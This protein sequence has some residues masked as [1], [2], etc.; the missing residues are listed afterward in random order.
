MSKRLDRLWNREMNEFGVEVGVPLP[1]K[2]SAGENEA[3]GKLFC[4]KVA[5][6]LVGYMH[7]VSEVGIWC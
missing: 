7:L 3:L 5:Q 6:Q 1:Q 4:Q 2:E